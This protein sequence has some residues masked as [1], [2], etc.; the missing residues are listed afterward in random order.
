M[1]GVRKDDNR[2]K[3]IIMTSSV[4]LVEEKITFVSKNF[5]KTYFYIDLNTDSLSFTI[6]IYH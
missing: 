3:S 2:N 6:L 4:V 1:G 5:I